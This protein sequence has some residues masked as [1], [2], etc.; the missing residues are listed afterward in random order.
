MSLSYNLVDE[1]WVPCRHLQGETVELS[2]RELLLEAHNTVEIQAETPLITASLLRL[3]FALAQRVENGPASVGELMS[4]WEQGRFDAKL[5]HNYLDHWHH[6]FD[7]F[8]DEFPFLQVGGFSIVDK[9]GRPKPPATTAVLKHEAA[10]GNNATLFDHASDESPTALNPAQAARRLVAHQF[11][12]VGGGKGGTS[13]RFG[14]HP[15]L[16][17]GPLVGGVL[18]IPIGPTLFHTVLLNLIMPGYHKVPPSKDDAP[19]WEWDELPSPGKFWPDGYLSTLVH[20][21]RYCRL[22]TRASEDDERSV[23]VVGVYS[24]QGLTME[25]GPTPAWM[26]VRPLKDGTLAPVPMRV[27]RLLW[28]DAHVF[29]GSPGREG[30]R[31]DGRP[32]VLRQLDQ[33][34]QFVEGLPS[35]SV[36]AFGL[37]NDKAKLLAWRQESFR[38][39]IGLL[40]DEELRQLVD[41]AVDRAEKIGTHVITVMKPIANLALFKDP[42]HRAKGKEHDRVRAA[43]EPNPYWSHMDV[44][45]REFLSEIANDPNYALA[46]L[47]DRCQN[48]ALESMEQ[49]MTRLGNPR[50]SFYKEMAKAEIRLRAWLA[51]TNR[52]QNLGGQDGRY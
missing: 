43:I 41:D 27:D 45:F 38:L 3:L 13:N 17:A 1:P 32:A 24:A 35:V 42:R 22:V 49:L 10:T 11:F 33:L 2:L 12:A 51:S 6:R 4:L 39:P 50:A 30:S 37:S 29:F 7:L 34:L 36:D 15:Y 18:L 20:P 52:Y 23:S 40:H 16:S 47:E 44:P 9:K 8:D 25:G 28:R 46:H 31:P 19:S 48:V 21:S 5:V 26:A 14:E